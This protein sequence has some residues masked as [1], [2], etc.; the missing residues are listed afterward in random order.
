MKICLIGPTYPYRGGIS[1]FTSFLK[2]AL[3]K[4]GHQVFLVSF[5]RQYPALLFPGKDD[6]DPTADYL[7]DVHYLIDSI[8][9]FTWMKAVRAI[10]A[11]G[12]DKVI[13]QWWHPYWAV[14]WGTISRALKRR[15]N[16]SVELIF[17][18]LVVVPHEGS[19]VD[20]WALKF[21]MQT[22]DR[23]I[24]YSEPEAAQLRTLFPKQ[25]MDVT[26]HPSYGELGDED[27]EQ[28]VV[29]LPAGLKASD[30]VEKVVLFAGFVRPY[31][32]LDVLIEAM[33]HVRKEL[34]VKL[35]VAGEF[36]KGEE[37]TREQI[38]QLGIA[39][40]VTIVSE[41]LSDETLASYVAQSDAMI[42]PYKTATSSGIVQLAF[43]H[44]TPVITSDVGDLPNIVHHE[45]TGLVVA[46][47]NPPALAG[48]IVRFY[49]EGLKSQF[50]EN[51][52]ADSGRFSWDRL[53]E[54][55]DKD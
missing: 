21:A 13:V 37:E 43:G 42:L 29:P 44:G 55:I 34:D 3:E 16:K 6:R 51:I 46:T 53:V 2:K 20:R 32:G 36:W 38:K 4:Q 40:H 17:S 22:A 27:E 10:T 39:D 11:W 30:P 7:P 25:P 5:S 41:Y 50:E 14:C 12:P 8:N 49:N 52:Q 26:P 31:K 33:P 18:C 47:E 48:A 54:V 15:L 23:F 19:F 28:E 1:H 24:V 45:K 35:L 9:P